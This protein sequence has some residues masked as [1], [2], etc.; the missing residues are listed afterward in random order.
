ME[1]WLSKAQVNQLWSVLNS[2]AQPESISDVRI[3]SANDLLLFNETAFQISWDPQSLLPIVDPNLYL[4]NIKLYI[5][6]NES[7][8]YEL[9]GDLASNHSN[10]GEANLSL[11][12]ELTNATNVFSFLV[13]VSIAYPFEDIFVPDKIRRIIDELKER[14]RKWSNRAVAFVERIIDQII[15]RLTPC[16]MWCLGQPQGIGDKL[17]RSVRPCPLTA[18]RARLPNS[19]FREDTDLLRWI[20]NKIFHAGADTCFR[21]VVFDE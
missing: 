16:E 10:F 9:Y 11:P 20:L 13:E 8:E 14:I 3:E 2:V 15:G 1:D 4:V 7:Q 6:S 12:E 5:L 17:L 19:G 21:Q 18:Q